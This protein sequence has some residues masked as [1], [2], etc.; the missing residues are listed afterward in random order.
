MTQLSALKAAKSPSDLAALLGF[1]AST[2]S[3]ILF[4][5]DDSLKYKEFDIPKRSGGLRRIRAPRPELKRLQ[6]NCAFLLENCVQEI[7]EVNDFEDR[8]AHGFKRGRSIFSNAKVHRNKKWVFNLDLE[9]FFGAINFGRVRGYFIKDRNFCLHPDVATLLAKIAC[10]DNSL[11]QGSPCSPVI[12]NLIG[13]LLDV[14][15]A[16]IAGRTGCRYTR[17]ADDLTFSS[18]KPS[19]PSEIAVLDD[20]TS[21]SWAVGSNVSRL[22]SRAGFAVNDKK[23]RMQYRNSRQEVTG[24]VVN[25]KVNVK[26][27]YRRA[28]RA[29]VHHLFTTGQFF[30][31]R[32]VDDDKGVRTKT[33]LL[34]TTKQ[35]HGMLGFIDLVDR[36]N[37]ERTPELN[38]SK[39]TSA[40]ASKEQVYKRFLLYKDF[41]ASGKPVIIC[42]GETDNVYILHAIR[43]LVGTFPSLADV[44][45]S[46]KINLLVRLFKYVGT[47]T[48][49]ILN[50]SGGSADLARFMHTYDKEIKRFGPA[51]IHHPVIILIDNDAG[52]VG[53]NKPFH[54][55]KSIN[56][57]DVDQTAPFTHIISNLYLVPT[58]LLAGSKQSVIE[59]CFDLVVKSEVIGGKTF[60]EKSD[61]DPNK[62]YGKKVFAH[63]VVRTQANVI[64]FSGFIPLLK[65]IELAM[66]DFYKKHSPSL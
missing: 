25:K 47:S 55:A 1:K 28:V 65:N 23:T 27:E 61:A 39:N 10:F 16:Q 46:G 19:F 3:Y 64:D 40:L 29:M 57:K 37:K 41:Y 58:P 56:K 26:C 48:G 20:I 5:I 43:R 66:L 42:E 54:A 51:A 22:I 15:L 63:K 53:K 49:R 52:A 44:D 34:G 7:N 31:V 36:Y 6:R 62:Y 45:A 4:G 59:D 13:H 30:Y 14:Q 8:I 60:C 12:S 17:Y 38:K 21:D 11:P 32:Y 35:L 18:S 24:L 33:Q 9:N 2:L 50:L